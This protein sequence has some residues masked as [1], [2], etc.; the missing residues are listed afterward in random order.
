M[1]GKTTS[2]SCRLCNQRPETV[3]HILSG[4]PELAQRLYLWRHNDALKHVLSALQ[5]KH[6]L[7]N[8]PLS[9]NQELKSYYTNQDRCVEIMWDCSVTTE[10]R[11]PDEGN[12][13][14]LQIIDQEEKRIDILEM[15]CPSWRNRAE[16][17]T[18]KYQTVRDEM[19]ERYQGYDVNQTNII[20]DI[21]GGYDRDLTE[22]LGSLIRNEAARTALLA[23]QKTIL[24]HAMRIMKFAIR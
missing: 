15:A 7:R 9:Q 24:I 23:M 14:D 1:M 17:K 5:M 20:V 6:G 19:R 10:T 8:K 12:R 22:K 2:T 16:R 18:R 21:L 4:C 13:P 11:A 3:E